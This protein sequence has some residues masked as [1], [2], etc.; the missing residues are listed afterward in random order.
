LGLR[1]AYIYTRAAFCG[2]SRNR[3]LM[4]RRI[5]QLVSVSSA[6]KEQ[7]ASRYSEPSTAAPKHC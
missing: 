2:T 3:V 1:V 4:R 6:S 7:A 5:E